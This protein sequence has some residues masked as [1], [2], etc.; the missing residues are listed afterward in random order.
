MGQHGAARGS[1]GQHWLAS[2]PE[3]SA[4]Q[5]GAAR[6]STRQHATAR[7]STRQHGAALG[8]QPLRAGNPY[9]GKIRIV[10]GH[11]CRGTFGPTR[12]LP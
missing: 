2:R 9:A 8:R 7:D 4:G 11:P 3:S 10:A 12:A 6:G 1:T 5:H